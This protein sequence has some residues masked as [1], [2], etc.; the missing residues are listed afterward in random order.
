VSRP[1]KRVLFVCIG[2]SCRSQMAEAFARAYG[3][4]VLIAASAGVSPATDIARDTVRAM[5]EKNIDIRDHFPKSLRHLGRS[6]FDLAINMS[7]YDI[8]DT[9]ATEIRAWDVPDPVSLKYEEHCEVRDAIERL[10]MTLI[11]ELRR[12]QKEPQLRGFG[13]GHVPL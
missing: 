7:G 9:T 6:Q 12:A 4:D 8:P 5:S 1:L 2:N 3:G 11:T 10:V 13:S